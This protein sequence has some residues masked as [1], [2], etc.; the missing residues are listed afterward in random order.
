MR[1]LRACSNKEPAAFATELRLADELRRQ[2]DQ[3]ID[4]VELENEVAR[5]P[6]KAAANRDGDLAR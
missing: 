1:K 4:L 2:A 3:F 5:A 6:N